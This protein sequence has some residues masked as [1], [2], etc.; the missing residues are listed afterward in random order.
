M[1]KLNFSPEVL[2]L[3]FIVSISLLFGKGLLDVKTIIGA[4]I[5]QFMPQPVIKVAYSAYSYNDKDAIESLEKI[6]IIRSVEELENFKTKLKEEK[7]DVKWLNNKLKKYDEE[8][9]KTKT[10]AVASIVN[11]N[12]ISFTRISG[13]TKKNSYVTIGVIQKTK[14]IEATDK[15]TWLSVLEIEDTTSTITINITKE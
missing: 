6:S 5:N 9:F 11:D 7:I 13:V 12:N 14:T 3:I 2:C 1:K 15:Y 10:L 4:K 8:F